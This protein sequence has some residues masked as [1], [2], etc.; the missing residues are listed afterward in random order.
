MTNGIGSCFSLGR[1]ALGAVG[2]GV[3][4]AFGGSIGLGAMYGGSGLGAGR[5][6]ALDALRVGAW[7]GGAVSTWGGGGSGFQGS[8]EVGFLPVALMSEMIRMHP[9]TIAN[10]IHGPSL[11]KVAAATVTKKS[12]RSSFMESSALSP[13]DWRAMSQGSCWIPIICRPRN[14][15]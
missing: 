6:G 1:G 8:S 11:C 13:G 2:R 9:P 4:G 3:L 5:T 12:S 10:D 14:S 15:N 7:C